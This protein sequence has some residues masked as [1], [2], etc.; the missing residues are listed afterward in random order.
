MPFG[1]SL[2]LIAVGAYRRRRVLAL[3]GVLLLLITSLPAFSDSVCFLLEN[4]YPHLQD[5]QRP[6][7]D[8]VVALGASPERRSDSPARF[9][10]MTPSTVS[11]ER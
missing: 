10:G 11:R 2:V 3:S 7:A 5:S 6:T 4:Q 9:N 8:V 1:L